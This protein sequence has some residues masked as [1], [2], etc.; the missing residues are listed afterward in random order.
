V[1]SRFCEIQVRCSNGLQE[2][3]PAVRE[4]LQERLTRGK[5][6]A[7][8]DWEERSGAGELPVLNEAVARRYL[9]EL[10]R[11]RELTGIETRPDWAALVRLPGL[12]DGEAG[13]EDPAAVQ[14][15]ILEA[16]DQALEDFVRMREAEGMALARDL[17]QRVAEIEGRLQRI[18][19][20]AQN[21]REQVRTRLREKV[22]ALLQPGEVA[23][24]RL[25]LEV[26]L[27]AERSDIAEE[28]VRFHSHNAQFVETLDRGGEVGRR[29]NFLLQEMNRE[30][31]T[32]SS[33]ASDAE[34]VRLAVEVKE[35][36]ERLR[37]QVQNLA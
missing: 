5:I 9:R 28:V 32:I 20:Q 10:E 33:K 23:E 2:I 6:T 19:E 24:E 22:A 30:A 1:N 15:L 26:V 3:E 36:V 8:V 4:R 11:L 25:A 18:G 13:A 29:L 37:E 27:I 34:I 31:N 16:V 12:F 17:R 14:G 21:T 35:E 7:Q